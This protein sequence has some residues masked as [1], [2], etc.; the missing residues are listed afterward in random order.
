MAFVPGY[1][2]DVFVSYAHIDNEPVVEG[3]LGWVDFFETLFRQRLRVRLGSA[4]VKIFRD[5]HL[6]LVGDFSD[7][8]VQTLNS[9]AAFISIL[10]P[11]YVDSDWCVREIEKFCDLT[12]TNRI[13][14]IV[15]TAYDEPAPE[16]ARAILEK[17]KN[18]LDCRFY[19]EDEQT[20]RF[21]DLQPEIDKADIPAALDKVD[22]I[23]Q[24]LTR[25]L[26]QLRTDARPQPQPQPQP[27]PAIPVAPPRTSPV[28]FA[29]ESK[30]KVF[31]AATTR[32]LVKTR[33]EIKTELSQ[34]QIDVLP[35]TPLPDDATELIAEV[36]EDLGATKLSIHLLGAN[37]G[38]VPELETRSIPRIQ[39]DLA[40]ELRTAGK[41]TQ[42]IWM[43]DGLSATDDRQRQFVEQVRNNS[44]EFLR[45]KIEDLKSEIHKKLEPPPS[46]PW[47][48]DGPDDLINLSL[49]FHP[50]D[51]SS[52]SPLY[53]YLTLDE[54]LKVKLPLKETDSLESHRAF[55][56]TS[57]AVI[58][59]YGTADQNW[60]V[61]MWRQ[62]QRQVS[63]SRNK[64]LLAKAI[65][66]GSPSTPEKDLLQSDE[67]DD[68]LIIKNYGRFSP[69][70]LDR[71]IGKLRTAQG[72]P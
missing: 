21:N 30:V 69:Q 64:P 43:P 56:Q 48:D 33:D 23:V 13:I 36:R 20:G 47:A 16:R 70:Y 61:N 66:A 67:D 1:E 51:E 3:N 17:L 65:Y 40:N 35:N 4:D 10:S 58:L 14:K 62:I 5:P 24:D 34:Y 44:A 37:Y 11:R 52:V 2:Y 45:A 71:F 50:D 22:A 55:L 18:I 49:F 8:I 42:L 39:Y 53:S 6:Q 68:P 60:V 19:N 29:S 26:K 27:Q 25:L 28:P 41:L 54:F 59:Y 46:N 38:S 12:G 32:D 31:L 72:A 63:A 9:S 15:K 57:D 7:Q